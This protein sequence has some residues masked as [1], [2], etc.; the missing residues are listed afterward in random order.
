MSTSRMVACATVALTWLGAYGVAGQVRAPATTMDVADIHPGMRGYGLTVFHGTTP[1]RFDVEVIDVLHQFRPDQDLVL[2]RCEHPV[3]EDAATVAG[4]S[5][6]PI[7]LEGRLIGAYAYGWPF[8]RHPVAG[9]TPIRNML[10]E[11]HRAVRPASLERFLPATGTA[12]TTAPAPRRAR[13]AYLGEPYLGTTPVSGFEPFRRE[14]ASRL[15]RTARGES[16]QPAATPMLLGGF[17][18]EAVSLLEQELSPFGI[19]VLQV[20]GAGT[21]TPTAPARFVDGGG[22]AVTLARGDI[23]SMAIGTVT[24]VDG[25]RLIGFGHPMMEAGETGFPTAV[26]RVLHILSSYQR[27]FKIAEADAPLGAM[28]QDR[29]AAVVIDTDVAP[30]MIPVR[31]HVGGVPTAA[32]SDWNFEVASHRGVTPLLLASTIQSVVKSVAADQEYVTFVARSRVTL[33][34]VRGAID[35]T[36]RGFAATGPSQ[37]SALGQLRAFDLLE[38]AYTNPFGESRVERI[39]V[40]IELSFERRTSEIV[41]ANVSSIE[42]DPGS[43]VPITVITRDWEGRE[44]ATTIT[45]EIPEQAAGQS[46]TVLLQP[47]HEVEIERPEP[48]SLGDIVRA[49]E[50]RYLATDLVASM[51]LATRGLRSPGHVVH[52][53]PSSVLDAMQSTTDSDRVRAFATQ[54]RLRFPG[55]RVLTGG[56]RIDLTVRRNDRQIPRD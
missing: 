9:V 45:V 16:F 5:G 29:Q 24:H 37:A 19:E 42:V 44:T 50:S 1:E 36:D 53:V 11:L 39:E 51:R 32:R 14:L 55:E 27:S 41:D 20:G 34:G 25:H 30:V 54:E 3:L 13:T 6:S 31:L 7:Y 47:G 56:A 46:L 15:P 10:R 8:G 52:S 18:P 12:T 17:E 26:G 35:V 21:G 28:V 43:R 40:D 2:I 49:V 48:R 4:M 23:S 22:L 38:A 33:E